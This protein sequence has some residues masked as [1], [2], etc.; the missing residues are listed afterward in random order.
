MIRKRA[1]A[2]LFGVLSLVAGKS[3]TY[4]PVLT[5]EES[6]D[7]NSIHIYYSSVFFGPEPF[8]SYEYEIA[9]RE[10]VYYSDMGERIPSELIRLLMTSL[11]DLYEAEEYEKRYDGVV[12]ADG[13]Y[14]F[15]ITVSLQNG[16]EILIG[17]R[18]NLHCWIPWNVEYEGK[19]YV[20]YNGRIPSALIKIL[21]VLDEWWL[22]YDKETTWGCYAFPPPERYAQE[23]FSSDFP[24]YV[25]IPT[26]EEIEARSHLLWNS[27]LEEAIMTDPLYT[28]GG[29]FLVTRNSVV[30]LDAP[31]G[32][33][34]WETYISCPIST[35]VCEEGVLYLAT[36]DRILALDSET[37]DTLWRLAIEEQPSAFMWYPGNQL[38]LY[39]GALYV[40]MRGP[41]VYCVDAQSGTIFWKYREEGNTI[42]HLWI[43]DKSVIVVS[44]A[45]SC[46]DRETGNLVWKTAESVSGVQV[47]G[48]DGVILCSISGRP[49]LCI[50]LLDMQTGETLWKAPE[51]I[52]SHPVYREGLLYYGDE[53]AQCVVCLDVRAQTTR[54]LYSYQNS[55]DELVLLEEGIL[56]VMDLE[57]D[58]RSY[59]DR[60]VF[61]NFSGEEEWEEVYPGKTTGYYVSRPEARALGE[62]LLFTRDGII[63]AFTI[64]TGERRW[65]SEV[66]GESTRAVELYDGKIYTVADDTTLYCLDMRTGEVV[67]FF[68]LDDELRISYEFLPGLAVMSVH[69]NL[70]IAASRNGKVYGFSHLRRSTYTMC[71]EGCHME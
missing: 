53:N 58:Q 63:E 2:V 28:D 43:S 47:Y 71:S 40:G 60:L 46:V 26:P 54:W 42:P 16:N 36:V 5:F 62:T 20:Q 29:L 32:S 23:G 27:D 7:V 31:T 14:K 51:R 22:V 64:S 19:S 52:V 30:C 6:Y 10:G 57:K 61:L 33:L 48:E 50:G 25:P 13:S 59:L 66:R 24:K 15:E 3:S 11:T 37:G 68:E 69:E 8:K 39:E 12:K 44:Q 49:Y 56:L 45:M 34:R 35:I 38:W 4:S 1:L 21:A 41:L 55:L 65:Q 18:N 70:I 9:R 17:S 67:W